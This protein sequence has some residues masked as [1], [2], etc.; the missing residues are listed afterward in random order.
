[1]VEILLVYHIIIDLTSH[2]LSHPK[3]SLSPVTDAGD[4]PLAPPPPSPTPAAARRRPLSL[5]SPLSRGHLPPAPHHRPQPRPPATTSLSL[6]LSLSSS[7]SLF[8]LA[9]CGHRW[10]SLEACSSWQGLGLFGSP[11]PALSTWRSSMGAEM[12][13][14]ATLKAALM[15]SFRS[16][17]LPAADVRGEERERRREIR[18]ERE[19]GKEIEV[20]AGGRRAGA[21]AGGGGPLERGEERERGRE[22]E[23]KR[24]KG[25]AGGQGWGRWWGGWRFVAGVGGGLPAVVA[26]GGKVTGDGED[27]GWD[28]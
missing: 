4:P 7:F 9:P 24:E 16:L 25:V 13:S 20:V 6:P 23:E 12:W 27:F 15:S 17:V 3:S 22:R 5:S 28:G 1:M 8:C 2:Y 14:M 18:E 19:R 26:G 21:G 11:W 10:C